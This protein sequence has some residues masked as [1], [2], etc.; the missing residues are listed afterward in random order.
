MKV[1]NKEKEL[2]ERKREVLGPEFEA[3]GFEKDNFKL[4]L[5]YA[6]FV[7]EYWHSNSTNFEEVGKWHGGRRIS[8]RADY[9]VPDYVYAFQFYDLL[10]VWVNAD[11]LDGKKY[12]NVSPVIYVGERCS[13]GEKLGN[14]KEESLIIDKDGQVHN[15]S[16][17]ITYEEYL[18][19]VKDKKKSDK[20]RILQK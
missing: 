16:G 18:D 5:D 15:G 13:L 12:Y 6:H 10:E 3:L 19:L 14:L 11:V 1:N 4:K 17:G 7:V 2:V 9:Q 20:K 8:S